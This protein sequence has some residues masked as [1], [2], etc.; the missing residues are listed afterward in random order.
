MIIVF[1]TTQWKLFSNNLGIS[2]DSYLSLIGSIS[3]IF[4]GAGRILFGWVLDK[5]GSFRVTLGIINSLLSIFLFTWPY[6][7]GNVMPFIWVCLLFGLVSSNFSIFPTIISSIFGEKNVGINVGL[8]FSSQIFSAFV[9]IYIFCDAINKMVNNWKY[10]CF[11]I[12]GIQLF[13][14]FVSFTF[15]KSP[16][17]KNINCNQIT[18]EKKNRH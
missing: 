17:N 2:N 11:I 14:S 1:I 12:A 13:G 6:C 4:N 5:N 7:Y 9:G 8:I 16:N 10:M 3:A 15:N 18:H